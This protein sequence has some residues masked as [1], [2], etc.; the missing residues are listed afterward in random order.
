MLKKITVVIPCYN[1]GHYLKDALE[2]LALCDQ[3]L[4][5][6]IIVNDGSDDELTN[7]YLSDLKQQG[8]NVVF[9]QNK[10][11][12]EARNTGI[13]MSNTEYILPLDADNKILPGYLKKAIEILDADEQTAVVYGNAKMFGDKNDDLIPGQFNLQ[14]LMIGNF[15]DACA[16]IR[17]SVLFKVGMYDNM[18]IMGYED[19]DLWLKIAFT[20]YRFHYINEIVFQY[21]VRQNSMMKNV[22]NSIQR[23]NEIEDYFSVKYADKLD[24]EYVFERFVYQLKKKPFRT[25]QYLVLRR[26]FPRYF[27]SLI[28]Q[29]KIRKN[30]IYD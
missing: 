23:Q 6:I 5:D 13:R 26:F 16:V 2:S 12:G 21:R 25:I 27:N 8:F 10:G 1:Q 22:N 4:F 28:K 30:F 11:L 7:K 3:S 14:R 29:N 15:I 17:R 20:G 19:W 18:K 9:Q 24:F